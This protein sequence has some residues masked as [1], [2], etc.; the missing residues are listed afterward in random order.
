MLQLPERPATLNCTLARKQYFHQYSSLL[1]VRPWAE[2]LKKF[3][4]FLSPTF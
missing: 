2:R 1:T 4:V 3:K